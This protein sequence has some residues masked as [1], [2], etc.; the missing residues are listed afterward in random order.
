MIIWINGAFGSGKTQ[1]AYELHRRIKNSY[2]YDPENIGFF[3]RD[4]IP[5]KLK[6][7]DFQNYYLWRTFNYDMLSYIAE[8][9]DGIIIV[10]MTI[11]SE[12]YYDE[13]IGK[14]SKEFTVKHFILS[15]AKETILK[16]LGRRFETKS[17]WAA[18]Q[19][20]RC[21]EAFSTSITE[22]KI[23]T[24]EMTI[25]EVVQEI[26]EQC[27]IKLSD[28][29]RNKFQKALDRIITQYKHIR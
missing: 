6:N 11:T 9:Y 20:D 18:Q 5:P 1:A 16:R 2:V 25:Y 14:L 8:S 7:R 17:S 27:S 10:P 28:D 13:I 4:N 29:N 26:A 21:I 15:A 23:Q 3:I 12:Q 24:D 22:I 19:I